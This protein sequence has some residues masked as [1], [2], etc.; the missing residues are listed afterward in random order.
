L[1]VIKKALERVLIKAKDKS[2]NPNVR[3]NALYLLCKNY[4]EKNHDE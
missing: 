4:L 3:G 2:E 1:E